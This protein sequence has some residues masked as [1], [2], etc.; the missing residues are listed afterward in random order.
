MR[1][2]RVGPE[3]RR[4]PPPRRSRLEVSFFFSPSCCNFWR[5][6]SDV[7]VR[8]F[9]LRL[10]QS[11]LQGGEARHGHVEEDLPHVPQFMQIHV[12]QAD[13]RKGQEGFTAPP[14]GGVGEQ[15]ALQ[16][17]QTPVGK[18]AKRKLISSWLVFHGSISRLGRYEIRSDNF[19]SS[20]AA[21]GLLT[22]TAPFSIRRRTKGAD[23]NA[24]E[25][26]AGV[27]GTERS[28]TLV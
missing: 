7:V 8:G 13:E 19:S 20:A 26:A 17:R 25:A 5:S 1:L 24:L 18:R 6:S 22:N 23:E 12:G 9:T 16:W 10:P 4:E 3:D 11:D 15:V 27:R 21:A 2:H 28:L 14:H